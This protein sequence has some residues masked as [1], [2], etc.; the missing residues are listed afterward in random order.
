MNI[1][2]MAKQTVIELLNSNS[3]SR[4]TTAKE[5]ADKMNLTLEDKVT[6]KAISGFVEAK[7]LDTPELQEFVLCQGRYGGIREVDLEAIKADKRAA[8]IKVK[9]QAAAAKAREARWAKYTPQPTE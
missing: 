6:A 9:R 5:V 2:E 3:T 8:E 4:R 1:I 7:L